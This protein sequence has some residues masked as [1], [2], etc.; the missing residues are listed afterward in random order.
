MKRS[1]GI[2]TTDT[3]IEI[4]EGDIVELSG[5]NPPEKMLGGWDLGGNWS[6][7][8]I[9]MKNSK[10]KWMINP[11]VFEPREPSW[12]LEQ[13]IKED[14]KMDNLIIIKEGTE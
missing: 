8:G 13:P 2:F 1:T 6:I 5:F 3:N 14:G 11:R 10:K 4:K 9:V 7:K 12:K